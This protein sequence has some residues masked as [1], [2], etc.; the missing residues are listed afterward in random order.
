MKRAI[1]ILSLLMLVATPSIY[2]ESIDNIFV[3][4][5]KERGANNVRVGS[6][7]MSL[8]NFFIPDDVGQ[9]E[10]ELVKNINA[11]H[12]LNMDNADIN[13]T[14]HYSSRIN[15]LKDEKG[16]ETLVKVKDGSESVRIMLRRKGDIIKELY[17]I[18]IDGGEI[19]GVKIAGD[20]NPENIASLIEQHK[21]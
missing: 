18:N 11:V 10:R 15:K 2:A 21:K 7:L 12:V 5:S 9:A 20:I 4:M 14:D 8:A 6:F 13:K 17:I 3:D 16:Y 1:L 19:S